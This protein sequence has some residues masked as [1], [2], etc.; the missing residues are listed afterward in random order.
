MPR[1][2][3]GGNDARRRKV[4]MRIVVP[5]SV[6]PEARR[7]ARRIARIRLRRRL[8]GIIAALLGWRAA[9]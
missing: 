5:N 9:R 3:R 7:F 6:S 1:G 4:S 8:R 2:I